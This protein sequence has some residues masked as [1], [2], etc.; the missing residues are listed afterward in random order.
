MLASLPVFLL[1]SC[2]F[3][4]QSNRQFEKTTRQLLTKEAMALRHLEGQ[5]SNQELLNVHSFSSSSYRELA[6]YTS[7]QHP[8]FTWNVSEMKVQHGNESGHL[9]TEERCNVGSRLLQKRLPSLA[10]RRNIPEKECST[11]SVEVK[12]QACSP[13]RDYL[14]Q[15]ADEKA[16]YPN[17][18]EGQAIK[19]MIENASENFCEYLGKNFL[20]FR[21]CQL[22]KT[23]STY[24]GVK[25][26]KPDEFDFMIEVPSLASSNAVLFHQ[27]L[28][29]N[30]HGR[31]GY[32]VCDKAL[33]SDIFDYDASHFTMFGPVEQEAFMRAIFSKLAHSIETVFM[34]FLP[35]G[36][37]FMGIHHQPTTNP[38]VFTMSGINSA[39]RMALTPR[40]VWHGKTF[41]SLK[42]TVD[43]IF[44]IPIMKP[45]P[46]K[47]DLFGSS[48]S[49]GQM[50]PP[51]SKFGECD[52][53]S[54]F[55]SATWDPNKTEL[56]LKG[57]LA[58]PETHQD[59]ADHLESDEFC[60]HTTPDVF[61]LLLADF[62]WC[63]AS[64]SIQ[65]QKIMKTFDIS[66]GQ[67]ICMRLIKYLRSVFIAQEYDDNTLDLKPSIPTYW[68]KTIMY[69]MFE[70][71]WNVETMWH[72]DQLHNRVLEVFETLLEC[73][74]KS[75]LHSFFVPNYNLLWMR[76]PGEQ[77]TL[78]REVQSLL[79]LLYSF[80]KGEITMAEL[81][82][83]E[84][85]LQ[86][87]NQKVLYENRKSTLLEMLLTYSIYGS[88]EDGDDDEEFQRIQY[89]AKHF[90]DGVAGHTVCITGNG[91]D[92][93]FFE[94]GKNVNIGV[95]EALAFLNESHQEAF[96]DVEA[97]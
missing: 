4:V 22:L 76:K 13:L 92:V 30:S 67:K 25:I 50:E 80:D 5:D 65:E 56:S 36:W 28:S 7:P 21:N 20:L 19:S 40:F 35:A 72:A 16:P 94:D 74:K 84:T 10:A 93:V 14:L 39:A 60:G 24:E 55:T 59:V 48:A 53:S 58:S 29:S 1:I 47:K 12:K 63:R 88:D 38:H 11:A 82:T 54:K 26:G 34:G 3:A 6:A 57:Q 96:E 15:I 73:L 79:Q 32:E 97:E 86:R 89:F 75:C 62:V 49:P 68:L 83:Q 51:V 61:H 91:K 85:R 31:I 45:A 87:D 17:T 23:G 43:F 37:E 90:L 18:M 2:A 95:E 71:Y 64:F 33:F 78:I 69:Y 41:P 77:E 46:P 9:D 8:A 52:L 27:S 70:K 42:V 44:A 81:E 66:D